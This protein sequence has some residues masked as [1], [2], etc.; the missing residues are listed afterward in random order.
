[1]IW[2]SCI[3]TLFKSMHPELLGGQNANIFKL[4]GSL[5]QPPGV[6]EIAQ[7]I[8]M[9]Q[10]QRI[11]IILTLVMSILI[12]GCEPSQPNVPSLSPTTIPIPTDI[13]VP[14]NN[15]VPTDTSI[16][17]DIPIPTDTP[18]PTQ[19]ETTSLCNH[20][21]WPIKEGNTWY[22]NSNGSTYLQFEWVVTELGVDEQGNSYFTIRQSEL[23]GGPPDIE[24]TY[25]CHDGGFYDQIGRL[26]L[27]PVEQMNEV[28]IFGDTMENM[29]KLVGGAQLPYKNATY[30]VVLIQ[31]PK[32]SIDTEWVWVF[33]KDLGLIR[34][35][36]YATEVGR[37]DLYEDNLTQP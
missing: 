10:K 35:Y 28:K 9:I 32:D 15:P 25:Y 6:P 3:I 23:L 36:N 14:T 7:E 37:I 13:L 26:I 12:M 5:E 11:S 34:I 30:D 1:L 18:A 21:Y 29:T 31:I 8:K 17:T 16:P 27:P 20:P 24:F 33:A 22:Y 4:C 2:F 19:N